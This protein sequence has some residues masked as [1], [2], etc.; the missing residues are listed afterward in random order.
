MLKTELGGPGPAHFPVCFTPTTP[1][2]QTL[3]TISQEERKEKTTQAQNNGRLIPGHPSGK[4]RISRL[5]KSS[6]ETQVS[7]MMDTLPTAHI[8]V[9]PFLFSSKIPIFQY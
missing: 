6:E 4:T 5:L 1:A 3:L 7:V 2:E 9:D 8:M